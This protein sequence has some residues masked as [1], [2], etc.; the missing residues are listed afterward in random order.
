MRSGI[1]NS[2]FVSD[3]LKRI[4]I[5][6]I[7]LLVLSVLQTSFFPMLDICPATPDL[8]IAA[9]A[10]IALLDTDSAAFV[11]ALIF[12]FFSDA[13]GASGIA[14]SPVIY[15]VAVFFV[16]IFK[17]KLLKS[18]ASFLLLMLPTLLCRAL[19]T[20]IC[21]WIVG[22]AF[23]PAAVFLSVLLPEALC[24]FVFGLPMYF[25]VKLAVK[26]LQS[27]GRFTF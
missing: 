16:C 15:F 9:L 1:K 4:A 23:P 26:P 11:C 17:D 22:G 2:H 18:F 5:Y 6:G 19:G 27:H 7:M 13:L 25:I 24:T 20:Y 12:G 3:L 10:A 21:I 8:L 14:P